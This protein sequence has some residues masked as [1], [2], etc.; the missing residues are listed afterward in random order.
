M[1]PATVTQTEITRVLQAWIKAGLEPG[2]LV[3]DG[4][5]IEVHAIKSGAN[6]T[7][8]KDPLSAWEAEHDESETV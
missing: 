6:D 1:K 5:K 4:A 8:V 2:R 7:D 3:V